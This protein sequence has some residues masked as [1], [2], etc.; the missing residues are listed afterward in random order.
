MVAAAGFMLNE[1]N[2]KAMDNMVTAFINMKRCES[3]YNC[4]PSAEEKRL[5]TGEPSNWPMTNMPPQGKSRRAESRA[6]SPN[7]S[8]STAAK[9]IPPIHFTKSKHTREIGR[10]KIM[11]K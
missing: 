4:R 2:M 11:R 8:V 10:D 5:N 9:I 6:V 7:A 3:A 1:E